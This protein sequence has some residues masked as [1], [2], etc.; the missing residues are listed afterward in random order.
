MTVRYGL[1]MPRG[2]RRA[3]LEASGNRGHKTA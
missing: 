2:A 1:C 3:Y